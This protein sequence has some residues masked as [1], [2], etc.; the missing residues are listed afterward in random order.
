MNLVYDHTLL[1]Q[2]CE[3]YKVRELR[4][5]GSFAKEN[6]KS[7]SDVD[8]LYDFYDSSNIGLEIVD[9][10]EELEMLFNRKVD[11]VSLKVVPHYLKELIISPSVKIYDAA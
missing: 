4:V 6:N 7:D 11:I 10:A 8:I 5:F 3:K 2:I 9:F 1:N